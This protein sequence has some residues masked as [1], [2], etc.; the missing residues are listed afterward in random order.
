MQL[1]EEVITPE[2]MLLKAGYSL[3]GSDAIKQTKDRVYEN[4]MQVLDI[5]VSPMD[6]DHFKEAN[7][8]GLVLFIIAPIVHRPWS[9]DVS[10][11][12]TMVS[13]RLETF[14]YLTNTTTSTRVKVEKKYVTDGG[15]CLFI[16]KLDP[17]LHTYRSI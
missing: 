13:R 12:F 14:S 16:N 8:S 3:H 15:E 9:R 10:W 7:V 4:I 1:A 11:F 17:C 5:E 6:S 2:D